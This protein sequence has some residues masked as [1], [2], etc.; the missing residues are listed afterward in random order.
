MWFYVVSCLH[1]GG[2]PL[3][4]LH[5]TLNQLYSGTSQQSLRFTPALSKPIVFL[6]P[7]N[8]VNHVSAS[9]MSS[10]RASVFIIKIFPV[11][12]HLL[13]SPYSQGSKRYFACPAMY[14]VL[15][16]H[17]D[18]CW[19]CSWERA[20]HWIVK[21]LMGWL[22]NW[23][24]LWGTGASS[25]L[26]FKTQEETVQ[27]RPQW[28]PQRTPE[29]K[30][31]ITLACLLVLDGRSQLEEDKFPLSHCIWKLNLNVIDPGSPQFNIW[32]FMSMNFLIMVCLSP[33]AKTKPA[34][35]SN[36]RK[37]KRNQIC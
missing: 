35:L 7:G 15:C 26:V 27:F 34:F 5:P 17:I 12:H 10:S 33:G 28:D 9:G 23:H 31:W 22:C 30:V 36:F 24:C 29:E 2:F 18:L 19:F 32:R 21:M 37:I 16:L 13:F 4:K 1:C 11:H 20:P 8:D 6:S 25:V 14:L 3:L